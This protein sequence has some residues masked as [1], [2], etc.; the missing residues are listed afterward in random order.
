MSQAT[1]TL[2]Y[3]DH[4]QEFLQVLVT[5]QR[6][7]A[8]LTSARRETYYGILRQARSFQAHPNPVPPRGFAQFHPSGSWRDCVKLA[9]AIAY[10]WGCI[11]AGVFS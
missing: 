3:A 4:L 5:E 11:E 1:P 6:D 2:C 7:P 9:M 10:Q 8:V